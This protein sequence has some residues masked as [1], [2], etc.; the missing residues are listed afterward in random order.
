MNELLRFSPA[1]VLFLLKGQHAPPQH[2]L[3]YT[4]ADLLGRGILQLIPVQE[5][6][7]PPVIFVAPGPAFAGYVP[8]PQERPLLACFGGRG[9]PR[10]LLRHYYTLVGQELPNKTLLYRQLN[11]S[12]RLTGLVSRAWWQQLLN[13]IDLTA[14]G[15][16]RRYR[17]QEEITAALDELERLQPTD[18][19]AAQAVLRRT[20]SHAWLLHDTARGQAGAVPIEQLDAV[21]AAVQAEQPDWH[22]QAERRPHDASWSSSGGNDSS[23]SDYSGGS[24]FGGSSGSSGGGAAAAAAVAGFGGGHTGGSGADGNFSSGGDFSGSDSSDTGGDSGCSSSG[25]SGCG[26]GGD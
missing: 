16:V 2:L 19:T 13:V 9:V 25:C 6:T 22:L 26:G 10:I 14:E 1:E 4:F 8:L 5:F 21:F 18:P 23:S 7:E 20:G 17:L 11:A 24:F 15:L 12:P 3:R